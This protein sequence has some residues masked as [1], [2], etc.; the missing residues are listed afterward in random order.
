[1]N[2]VAMVRIKTALVVAKAKQMRIEHRLKTTKK[3]LILF[4]ESA[5][6]TISLR[7]FDV[8]GVRSDPPPFFRVQ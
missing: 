2:A 8:Y 1:M 3:A 7:P 6:L 5:F 4:K